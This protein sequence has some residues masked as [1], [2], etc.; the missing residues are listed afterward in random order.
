MKTLLILLAFDLIS[1]G[2]RPHM[3]VKV[4]AGDNVRIAWKMTTDGSCMVEYHEDYRYVREI[5]VRAE[6]T[7]EETVSDKAK[8]MVSLTLKCRG[9]S[10][11]YAVWNV[12]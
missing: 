8:S 4:S 7:W 5:L 9:N 2:Q 12:K 1:F 10:T 3:T 11:Q 6:G